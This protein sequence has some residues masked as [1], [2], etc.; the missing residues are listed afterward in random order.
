M[1]P[2]VPE[3]KGLVTSYKGKDWKAKEQLG[4]KHAIMEARKTR[5]KDIKI[6]VLLITHQDELGEWTANKIAQIGRGKYHC[7]KTVENMPLNALQMF[8]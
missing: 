5:D 2:Q 1:G 7:V 8:Q 4:T 6:S 3:G